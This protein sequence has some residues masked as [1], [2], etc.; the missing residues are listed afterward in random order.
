MDQSSSANDVPDNIQ[1]RDAKI[2]DFQKTITMV[3]QLNNNDIY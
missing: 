3:K 2:S 1:V